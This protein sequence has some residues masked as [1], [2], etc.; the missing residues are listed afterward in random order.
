M[1]L[2]TK[3]KGTKESEMHL[4]ET[5]QAQMQLEE[6]AVHPNDR[7]TKAYI[8]LFVKWLYYLLQFYKESQINSFVIFM[9]R[10]IYMPSLRRFQKNFSTAIC[11]TV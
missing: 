10:E 7:Q 11:K 6:L 1:I 8:S 5:R 2:L 4:P 9:N 3:T